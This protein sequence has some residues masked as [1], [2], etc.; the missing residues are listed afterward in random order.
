M[1][2]AHRGTEWPHLMH[3]KDPLDTL[4]V[5][6]NPNTDGA[7]SLESFSCVRV[8]QPPW[9]YEIPGGDLLMD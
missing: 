7:D 5:A 1:V 4:R 6:R 3:A 8:E 2:D 9:D